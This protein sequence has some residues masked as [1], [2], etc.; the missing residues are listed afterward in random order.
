MDQEKVLNMSLEQE[1]ETERV[2]RRGRRDNSIDSL[3]RQ[4]STDRDIQ[5]QIT[6]LTNEVKTTIMFLSDTFE[7][8]LDR[9]NEKLND[10]QR[11]ISDLESRNTNN[12]IG[13]GATSQ[14][15]SSD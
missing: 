12:M 9:V 7:G 8:R 4:S 10:V 1:N 15:P 5:S 11:H 14:V 13:S 2:S 6:S 3:S